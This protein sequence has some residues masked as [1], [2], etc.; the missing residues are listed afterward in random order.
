MNS[1]NRFDTHS[2]ITLQDVYASPGGISML[3]PMLA[4]HMIFLGYDEFTK[5][6]ASG[7]SDSIKA[8]RDDFHYL[9]LGISNIKKEAIESCIEVAAPILIDIYSN[10]KSVNKNDEKVNEVRVNWSAFV[11]KTQKSL[12]MYGEWAYQIQWEKF[13]SLFNGANA[14]QSSLFRMKFTGF[15]YLL[16]SPDAFAKQRDAFDEKI[17]EIDSVIASAYLTDEKPDHISASELSEITQTIRAHYQ[18]FKVIV[19][20][21]QAL[22]KDLDELICRYYSESKPLIEMLFTMPDESKWALFRIFC[23]MKK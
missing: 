11:D 19:E 7:K 18:Q 23:R 13:S 20:E 1:Y 9:A 3:I 4:D 12:A 16:E 22:N 2:E 15:E 14:G 8:N 21:C 17:K 5:D 10:W 6:L